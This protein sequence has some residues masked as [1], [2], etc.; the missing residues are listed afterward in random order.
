[1]IFLI[2]WI[3][4]TFI[5]LFHFNLCRIVEIPLLFPFF[6]Y[7]Y[8]WFLLRIF[9]FLLMAIERSRGAG[10][11]VSSCRIFRGL[12][13]WK[14]VTMRQSLRF[15]SRFCENRWK[16]VTK[17]SCFVG[18][19]LLPFGKFSW[20]LPALKICYRVIF[21]YFNEVGELNHKKVSRREKFLL[22][23]VIVWI[24]WEFVTMLYEFL[25][26]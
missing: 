3:S 12:M 16:S 17:T 19:L 5:R 11:F 26:I 1:M 6:F 9:Y 24:R 15:F 25:D 8:C 18:N 14:F 4:V 22:T 2:R 13:R 21:L 7:S 10:V 23:S 20:F